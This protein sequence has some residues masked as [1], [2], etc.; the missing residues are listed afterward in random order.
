MNRLEVIEGLDI[1]R[2]SQEL[3]DGWLRIVE[4]ELDWGIP[5]LFLVEPRGERRHIGLSLATASRPFTGADITI[6]RK[7]E[8]PEPMIRKGLLAAT[9]AWLAYERDAFEVDEGV[10]DS[11]TAYAGHGMGLR[12]IRPDGRPYDSM[13]QEMAQLDKGETRMIGDGWAARDHA[14]AIRAAMRDADLSVPAGTVS[15]LRG[16]SSMP[17]EPEGDYMLVSNPAA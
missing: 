2:Q 7:L 13:Q 9:L 5:F 17:G 6:I 14:G 3:P 11:S 1:V 12:P 15:G 8:A 4:Q 16:I 10:L